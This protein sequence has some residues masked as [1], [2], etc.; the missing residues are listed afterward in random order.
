[1]NAINTV[2]K[3]VTVWLF[4]SHL[5]NHPIKLNKICGALLEKLGQ[6]HKRHSCMDS[7]T[8]THKY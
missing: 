7:D 5:I 8:W 3:T 1:M 6:T 2:Y 4:T